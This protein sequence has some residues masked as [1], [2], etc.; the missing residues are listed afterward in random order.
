MEDTKP[1][2]KE[3][4]KVKGSYDIFSNGSSVVLSGTKLYIFKP[5]GSLIACRKDLRHAG[6]ITFLSEDRMLLCSS[7]AV[8]HIIDLHDGGDLWTVQGPKSEFNLAPCSVTPDETC[9]YTYDTWRGQFFITRLDLNTREIDSYTISYDVGAT[10]D[11]L[12]DSEGVPCVLKTLSENI[13]GRVVTQNGVRIQDYDILYR[14]SSHYWKTK[15][16]FDGNRYAIGFLGSIDRVIT[17]DLYIYEP[18]SG[19]FTDPLEN[20]STWHRSGESPRECWTDVSGSYLCLEYPSGNAVIDLSKRLVAAQ[21]AGAYTRGCL[22]GEEYWICRNE[23]ICRK[24]FP[25]MEELQPVKAGGAFDSDFYA[26]HPA[27]W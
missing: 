9:A 21:Y 27:L 6:R 20:E 4:D 26:K 2:K 23:R 14:G 16:Q 22:I 7:K 8:Y 24:P 13:G 1:M 10:R 3:I 18:S 19:T 17:N 5:D 12:C 15:W 11:I 25:Q